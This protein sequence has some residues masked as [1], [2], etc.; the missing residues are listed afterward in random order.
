MCCSE[1]NCD[2]LEDTVTTVERCCFH[3]CR[4]QIFRTNH[5]SFLL[6]LRRGQIGGKLSVHLST[7]VTVARAVL[8]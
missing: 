2:S 4:E 5:S 1:L 6:Q 7:R 8:P 3:S